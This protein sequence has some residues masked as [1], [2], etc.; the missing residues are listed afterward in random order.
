MSKFKIKDKGGRF[1]VQI[2]GQGHDI[3]L[4]FCK[5][6]D[7]D[8]N[9]FKLVKAAVEAYEE[10]PKELKDIVSKLTE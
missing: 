4:S 5:A 1:Q 8:E 7:K 10:M 6:F 3:I 2:E 9:I